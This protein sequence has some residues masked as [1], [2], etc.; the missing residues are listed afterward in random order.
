MSK[1]DDESDGTGQ[2]V[3]AIALR[4]WERW[5]AG[6]IGVTGA[7]VGGTGVFLSDNQAGTTAILLI[8]ALFML[9]AV[10]GT[11][12]RSAS[13][14]SI[15]LDDRQAVD[16]LAEKAEGELEE[17]EPERA[18]ATIE[19]ASTV[20]PDLQQNPRLVRLS[21]RAYKREIFHALERAYSATARSF[22]GR[23]IKRP[24]SAGKAR[25]DAL[26]QFSKSDDEPGVYRAQYHLEVAFAP[27]GRFYSSDKL[28]EKL[29]Q[30]SGFGGGNLLI[31]S[32][33]TLSGLGKQ[34]LEQHSEHSPHKVRFVTWRDEDD[35]PVLIAAHRDLI[36]VS[37]PQA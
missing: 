5:L 30:W 35:D 25:F 20:R 1:N 31:V 22:S 24:W 8:G 4:R 26:I 28:N 21:E 16:R 11:P 27:T 13:R 2:H 33:R 19:G 37:S 17:D 23:A 12:L 6:A 36:G 14:D 9:L 10:Q 18:R 15:E 3:S 32:N 29:I 34:T 7:G